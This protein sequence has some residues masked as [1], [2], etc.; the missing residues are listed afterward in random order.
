ML[1]ALLA[2][3]AVAVSVSLQFGVPAQALAKSIGRVPIGP[4]RPPIAEL[5]A[6]PLG[7]ALDLLSRLE[8]AAK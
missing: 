7:A 6:S 4:D 2:D 5:P 8:A 1:N 3:A